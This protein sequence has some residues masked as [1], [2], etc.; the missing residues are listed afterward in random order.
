MFRKTFAVMILVVLLLSAFQIQP[1]QA[2]TKNDNQLIEKAREKVQEIGTGKKA[3]VEVKLQN[4]K[5]LKGYISAVSTD[6]FTVTDSETGAT[7][8]LNYTD[9][10]Q[11][12]KRGGLSPLTLGIIAG[13][14]VAAIII[15]V[16]VIKPVLCDGGAGC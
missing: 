10:K 6:S 2:Q 7:Q 5:K 3:R 1:L 12:K 9:V 16:T 13:A 11:V 15:G 8:T 14:A 4:N